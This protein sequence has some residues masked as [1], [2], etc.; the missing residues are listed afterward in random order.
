M[1]ADDSSTAARERRPSSS[2]HVIDE[3]SLRDVLMNTDDDSNAD[4]HLSDDDNQKQVPINDKWLNYSKVSVLHTLP[5]DSQ[6]A[7]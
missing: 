7:K 1:I 2:M 3:F 4:D 5:A 6:I